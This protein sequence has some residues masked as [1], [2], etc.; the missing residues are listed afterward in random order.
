MWLFSS[1]LRRFKFFETDLT[2]ERVLSHMGLAHRRK[3]YILK[4]RHGLI[5]WRRYKT[6]RLIMKKSQLLVAIREVIY[7]SVTHLGHQI[8][9]L[10][11]NKEAIMIYTAQRK[12]HLTFSFLD[13]DSMNYLKYSEENTVRD[14]LYAQI[15]ITNW[16]LLRAWAYGVRKPN[17]WVVQLFVS[18]HSFTGRNGVIPHW[19]RAEFDLQVLMAPQG[20][21]MVVSPDFQI[22][23]NLTL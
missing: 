20:A 15:M 23:K 22:Q 8:M 9:I 17:D 12:R 5:E 10:K 21:A 18:R 11:I 2:S 1:C 3:G 6:C 13:L 4:F 16:C 7:S 19:P 14:I